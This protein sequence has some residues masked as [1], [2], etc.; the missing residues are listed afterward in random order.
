MEEHIAHARGFAAGVDEPP[1]RAI[2][3][4]AGGG[5]PGL[6]LALE[7]PQSAWV[8]LDAQAR[9]VTF[10]VEAITRLDLGERVV[11]LHARAEDIGRD[12]THRSSYDL[13]TARSFG[14]PG[15][16]A[17]CAAP[18]LRVGGTLVVSEP[19]GSTGDRWDAPILAELG[20]ALDGITRAGAAGYAVLRQAAATSDRFPRRTGVPE[21]RPL[22]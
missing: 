7:W 1:A 13:V 11:A 9:R 16:V 21:R 22:F 4:G 17:E 5:V 10:L 15:V 14:P 2:D 3:L 6:V 19:P 8:L 20:L 12:P 18:L